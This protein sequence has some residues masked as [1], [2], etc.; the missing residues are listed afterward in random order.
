MRA[1]RPEDAVIT[2]AGVVTALGYGL[3]ASFEGLAAGTSS[4]RARDDDPA[5]AALVEAAVLDA[6]FLRAEV[7]RA[8]MAEIKFLNDAGEL[9]VEATIEAMAATGIPANSIPAERR[10]L[11]LSQMDTGDWSCME[12]RPAVLAATEDGANPLVGAALNEAANRGRKTKPHFMLESL[13]NNAF[14]FLATLFDLR[15]ANTSVAGF[16]GATQQ[17]IDLGVRALARGGMDMA[18]ICGAAR[19]TSAVARLEMRTLHLTP[20][21]GDGAGTLVL[22]RRVDAHARGATPIAALV[23]QGAATIRPAEGSWTPP[24]EALLQAARNALADADAQ[25][26]DLFGVIAPGLGEVGLEDA[27]AALPVTATLPV[28]RWKPQTGHMALASDAVE[29]ALAARAV[30]D[31]VLPGAPAGAGGG[32][33]LLLTAGSL[34]QAGA[35]V[36]APV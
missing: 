24:T 32:A 31:G 22:E 17:A 15:G 13:K 23:G 29:A 10:G 12:F 4:V 34:G 25:P 21:P 33:V 26:G 9:A 6:P 27:L 20:A 19:P 2:G 3:D 16:A 5:S 8:M 11:Y 36:V 1:P 30:R 35:F 7:P 28:V 14:S 18:V